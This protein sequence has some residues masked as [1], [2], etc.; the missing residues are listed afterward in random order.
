MS[1]DEGMHAR[2]VERRVHKERRADELRLHARAA[3]LAA[4]LDHIPQPVLLVLPG[5]S[6]RTWHANA[7]AR[8][9]LVAP[10]TAWL[11]RDCL[12][13]ADPACERLLVRASRRA[14]LRGGGHVEVA[15][16]PVQPGDFHTRDVH[17]EA[18]DVEADAGVPG[19]RMLLLEF[20]EHVS[21]QQAL[22][23][24]CDDFSLTPA[25]AEMVLGLYTRGSAVEAAR[26]CG[27]SI[28]TVRAQLKSAMQKTNTRTQAGLVALVGSRLG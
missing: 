15:R 2:P 21:P 25:E 5:G 3:C 9:E 22:Q 27:K 16:L 14:W 19:G 13:F 17:V 23:H 11:D 4:V 10:G 26:D 8:R 1:G 12:C 20:Q 7:A 24:L 6:M 28:H 18:I